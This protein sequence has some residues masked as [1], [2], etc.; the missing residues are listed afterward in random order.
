MAEPYYLVRSHGLLVTLQK[1]EYQDNLIPAILHEFVTHRQF[2]C[3]VQEKHKDGS[4]HV[5]LVLWCAEPFTWVKANIKEQTRCS[6][7]H[8]KPLYTYYAAIEASAY[9]C[10]QEVPQVWAIE[11]PLAD[12][13]K[14]DI[15]RECVAYL[16]RQKNGNARMAAN[17]QLHRV[18][19]T[20]FPPS[21]TS[22]LEL[23]RE[24][25]ASSSSEEA[26]QI[27]DQ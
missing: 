16:T 12:K 20:W 14:K 17:A 19:K 8:L 13:V 11:Q 2:G 3:G 23:M 6:M 25:W 1:A 21:S 9:L 15:R 27:S 24:V 5:H 26:P 10:K 18:E 7:V 22:E 4:P